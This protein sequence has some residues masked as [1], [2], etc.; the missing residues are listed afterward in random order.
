LQKQAGLPARAGAA[1]GERW[2]RAETVAAALGLQSKNRFS[3]AFGLEALKA[4]EGCG[5][6]KT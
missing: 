2:V 3:G 6:L 1:C 5:C 4:R